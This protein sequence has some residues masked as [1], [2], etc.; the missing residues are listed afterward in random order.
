[1]KIFIK[2]II[3]FP[4]LLLLAACAI[5]P[6]RQ[7]LSTQNKKKIHSTQAVLNTTQKGIRLEQNDMFTS[8]RP[9]PYDPMDSGPIVTSSSPVAIDLTSDVIL[10]SIQN[11]DISGSKKEITPVRNAL[12]N[13]NYINYFRSD[14][15]ENLSTLSWLKLAQIKTKYNIKQGERKVVDATKENSTLFVGTTYALNSTF[16]RL[17]VI[18]Y[19]KLDEKSKNGKSLNTLYKNNFYYIYRLTSNNKKENKLV[20]VQN[21]ASLLKSKLR[22]ASSMLSKQIADDINNSN[23][24]SGIAQEKVSIVTISGIK[25][26][27]NVIAKKNNYYILSLTNGEAIYIVNRLS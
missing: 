25:D 1:M 16:E 26:S 22:D 8:N 27:A 24:S 10:S 15:Q 9:D 18:A 21:N 4:V 12:G 7:A 19:V 2:C 3:L 14:L 5:E 17:E 20:W 11:H 23:L 6:Q 13:F